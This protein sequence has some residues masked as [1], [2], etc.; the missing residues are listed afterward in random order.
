MVKIQQKLSNKQIQAL[1]ILQM[2]DIVEFLF[3]GGAGGGKTK[4]GCIHIAS[5]ALKY[6]HTRYFIG[7]ESL[8]DFKKSTML[9]FVELLSEWG[10]KADLDYTHHQVDKYFEFHQTKARVYYSGLRHYPSDPNY[11]YLGSTE[12][13]SAFI[14]EANQVTAKA[15]NII[16]SRI[17]YK[18]Q[19]YGLKPK[20]FMGCNPAKGHLYLDFYK[21][22]KNGKLRSDRA[23]LQSLVN[24]NP[25]IDDTYIDNLKGL[26]K[27]SKERLLYG[28]WEYD[29]DPTALMSYDSITD[30]F[31]NFVDKG[32]EKWIVVDVARHGKDMTTISY[33]E[34]MECI[35]IAGYKKLDTVP[36]P[37]NP[38]KPST[39]G[40]ILEW[41]ELYQV[42]RSHIIVDEDGVGGG[43]KDYLGCKG[44]VANSSAMKNPVTK[45][46]ENF[47]NLKAQCAY[48]LAKFVNKGKLAVRTHN[49]VI[50][51]R[52]IEELEQVKSKDVDK[53]KKL[54]IVSKDVVKDILGRSPDFGDLLIM[55]MMAEYLVLP[56]MQFINI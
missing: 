15:K 1:R 26:D 4:L 21:P 56:S 33:W 24:D 22:H 49:P 52:L 6:P 54:A 3:G 55:R 45:E 34:G 32:G 25:F 17:R 10:L 37:N 40:K 28:N 23:F 46:V 35:R 13:T 8:E 19:E 39:A 38:E 16:R 53:D 5:M 47:V 48:T 43:V 12:Y 41:A 7:R 42:S 14:D 2:N 36:D 31:T 51:Q 30:I 29:D 18:L 20:L 44:F 50:K 27:E 11:D 9:T